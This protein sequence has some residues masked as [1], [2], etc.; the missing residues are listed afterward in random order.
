MREMRW[1]RRCV[2]AALMLTVLSVSLAAQEAKNIRTV[3]FVK[4]KPE[5]AGDWRAAIKEYVTLVKK[6]ESDQWFT[7]W[8][9]Q[10]GP[11]EYAVVWYSAKWKDLDEDM[12][13]KTKPVAAD[14][15]HVFDRLD[16]DTVSMETQ[17]DEIQPDLSVF[18]KEIPKMVRTGRTRVVQGKMDEVL[19]ILKSDTFPAMKKA[20][21]SAYGVAVARFGTPSNEIHTFAAIGG[22]GDLD[23]PWG[24]RKGMSE[25]EY[26]AY[27][28]RISPLIV[29]S[30][31]D[32]WRFRPE[33]SYYPEAK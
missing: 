3:L 13:P 15:A 11:S 23:S 14:I 2:L 9:S 17:V 8:E 29:F 20:G 6:S 25:D 33:L 12:D 31:Y 4:V 27:L 1:I 18:G 19:A 24:V 10:S 5:R 28:A 22:W 30:Q 7:V 32:M 26:K 21:V 16:G